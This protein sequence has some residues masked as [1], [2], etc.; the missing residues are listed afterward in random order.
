MKPMLRFQ[1]WVVYTKV[2]GI[3]FYTLSRAQDLNELQHEWCLQ[4]MT[5]S[6]G[7]FKSQ[8]LGVPIVAQW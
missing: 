6:T 1:Q 3:A 5:N 7:A 2:L 4:E 8:N